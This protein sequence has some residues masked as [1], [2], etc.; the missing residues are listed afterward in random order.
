MGLLGEVLYALGELDEASTALARAYE[1]ASDV[2]TRGVVRTSQARVHRARGEYARAMEF[3]DEGKR[4]LVQVGDREEEARV[5]ERDRVSP[6]R[7]GRGPGGASGKRLSA[8]A[9]A[10]DLGDDSDVASLVKMLHRAVEAD[11]RG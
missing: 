6:T 9:S 4:Y 1:I 10:L 5:F 11:R 7:P 2:R 8:L 3:A